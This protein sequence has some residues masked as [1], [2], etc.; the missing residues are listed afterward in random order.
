MQIQQTSKNVLDTDKIGRLLMKLTVPMFFGMLVQIIYNVVDTVFIGHYVGTLG[1]AS[2][3]IVFPLSMLAMGVGTMVGTG[4]AS[5][6]SRLIGARDIKGAE[7]AVGNG[8]AAGVVLAIVLT[9]IILPFIDFWITLIGAS[10]AVFPYARDYI[11]IIICGVVF[12]V[13]SNALFVYIRAEGNARVSMTAMVLASGLNILLDWV[14]IVPLGMGMS[15]A[16]LATV[17]AQGISVLYALSYYVT[18]NS[19]LKLRFKNF[20]PDFKIL[21]SIMA[22]GVAQFSQTI[23]TSLAALFIIKMA[24]T[25][26]GDLALSAFGIIQRLLFFGMMPGQ[27]LGQAM[28]PILGFN[29]GAKRYIYGL[30]VLTQAIVSATILSI[31][32][33]LGFFFLPGPI[34]KIFTSDEQLI[35]QCTYVMRIS[36][37]ALPLLGFFNVG[38]M[39]FPSIGKAMQTF[40][41]AVVRPGLFLLPMVIILPRFFGLDGVWYA[42]PG[43]DILTFILVT[44]L[45]L[46]LIRFFRKAAAEEKR[47][48]KSG[49]SET[50]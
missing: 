12:N 30:R 4:G 36:F 39:A 5:L 50:V 40:I 46:P 17:I 35:E 31:I 19:Y 6:I 14:F 23:A 41:I 37:L 26:G 7:R 16:A 20:K 45:L 38:S 21:K 42:F 13:L 2:L 3:S 11:T 24:A 43:S 8:I 18:G 33:F 10:E 34:V 29:Y 25:Y 47:K 32:L 44:I 1:I 27:V 22:I 28:Q 48:M 9:A 49:L 15:G